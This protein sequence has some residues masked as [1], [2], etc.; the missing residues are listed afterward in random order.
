MTDR[1]P[2]APAGE[3][4]VLLKAAR[5]GD[6]QA[7]GQ[8]VE[9]YRRALTIHSY[10]MLGSPH[11]AEDIVQ[12]TLL[13]AW[14]NLG[15]YEPRAPLSSWLY[16]IATNAS[17]DEIE[18][19]PRRPMPVEPYPDT[20]LAESDAPTYDPA[21]RYALREGLEF[22]L[23]R[24]IQQL[25]G[26]QRAVL[27][28]RDVLGWTSPEVADLLETSVAAVN[29]AL[30]RARATI[31][32]SIPAAGPSPAAEDERALLQRYVQAFA[33]DDVDGLVAIL[34]QDAV[35]RMPPQPA[36]IGADSIAAFLRSVAPDGTYANFHQTPRWANGRPAVTTSLRSANGEL[37]PHAVSVL[38]VDAGEIIAIETFLDAALAARFESASRSARA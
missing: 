9:P 16:R 4:S 13:R 20:P 25:P 30:Q 2:R 33:N 14:R 7:F 29:S 18:R 32:E 23:L 38:V 34:R 28:L 11:D 8:L 22:G 27:I 3:Q 26:R 15:S 21:A 17:L 37:V 19:R 31:D 1:V 36:V 10:R 24:A 5:S 35:L 12:E 6:Q